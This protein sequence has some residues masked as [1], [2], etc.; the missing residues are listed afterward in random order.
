IVVTVL[1]TM[2]L[3]NVWS[4]IAAAIASSAVANVLLDLVR[5]T[6]HQA[7]LEETDPLSAFVRLLTTNHRRYGAQ[8]THL[9]IMMIVVGVVGSSLFSQKELLSLKPGESTTFANRKIELVSVDVV[10]QP[11]FQALQATLAIS[12]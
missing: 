3:K 5:G 10:E 12:D 8:I 7:K 11:I 2:G 9:G 1:A 4:L 6:I